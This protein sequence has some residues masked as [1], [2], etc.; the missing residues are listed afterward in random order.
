MERL[1][2][3]VFNFKNFRGILF[4]IFSFFAIRLEIFIEKE[5]TFQMK[6]F[7]LQNILNQIKVVIVVVVVVVD[8]Y[9]FF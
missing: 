3:N 8:F 2:K 1:K 7:L 4:Q 6:E 5:F 9:F